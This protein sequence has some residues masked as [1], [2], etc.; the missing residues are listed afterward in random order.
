MTVEFDGFFIEGSI[1]SR[2]YLQAL[3]EGSA[4]SFMGSLFARLVKTGMVVLDVGA[5]LGQYSLLAARRVGPTG[6]VYAFEPDPRNFPF[7]MR[8]LQRNA[9]SDRVVVLPYAVADRPGEQTLFL[10]PAVG[11]GSS[12]FFRRRQNVSGTPVTCVALD[13]FL[14]AS[15]VV[16][17][18]KLDVEGGELRALNG[19]EKTVQRGSPRLVMFVECFPKGLR[20]AGASPRALVGR[21]EGLGFSVLVIDER[22]GRLFPIRSNTGSLWWFNLF[23]GLN[24]LVLANFLCIRTTDH[25]TLAEYT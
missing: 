21:L 5:F 20:S 7:L 25:S 13:E 12:L 6:Q 3:R 19:M 15:V 24:S 8:N 1:G 4:E 22:R 17:V 11:S 16:D 14:D 18:I 23:L 9:L 10:D 2:S